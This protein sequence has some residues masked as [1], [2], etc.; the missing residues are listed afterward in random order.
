MADPTRL[1][2][3]R[4]RTS[5]APSLLVWNAPWRQVSLPAWMPSLLPPRQ[6]VKADSIP[7]GKPSMA[8]PMVHRALRIHLRCAQDGARIEWK[9]GWRHTACAQWL[10]RHPPWW[11]PREPARWRPVNRR[12]EA[13]GARCR[14]R[15]VCPGPGF[16]PT[17]TAAP[18][19]GTAPRD[20][21]GE[22]AWTFRCRQPQRNARSPGWQ[23]ASR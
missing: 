7:C 8:I 1:N 14:P 4:G 16:A 18:H 12:R 13:P 21:I 9:T 2:D 11:A 20:S 3:R 15:G 17:T 22:S 23:D 5:A 10:R 6:W 19:P